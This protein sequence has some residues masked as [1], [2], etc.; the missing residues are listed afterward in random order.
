MPRV[1]G[2]SGL[3]WPKAAGASWTSSSSPVEQVHRCDE[4]VQI[5]LCV[6]M[7]KLEE[8]TTSLVQSVEC[9]KACAEAVSGSVRV[10]AD[11]VYTGIS[12]QRQKTTGRHAAPSGELASRASLVSATVSASSST[13]VSMAFA[14]SSP[15]RCGAVR[16]RTSGEEFRVSLVIKSRASSPD[17]TVCVGTRNSHQR[18]RD[19]TL[20]PLWSSPVPSPLAMAALATDPT[21]VAALSGS[22][23]AP[24]AAS[25][26]SADTRPFLRALIARFARSASVAA[27]RS[28]FSSGAASCRMDALQE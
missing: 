9:H 2:A 28:S 20:E 4:T 6:S 23:S 14:P 15:Y 16:I 24:S 19:S 1:I 7:R 13:S 10:S 8:L 21:G 27:L 26:T 22:V 3:Q 12:T 18:M 11:V 17:F 25:A 5:L